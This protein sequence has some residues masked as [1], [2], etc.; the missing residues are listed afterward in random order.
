VE[1]WASDLVVEAS[2][3]GNGISLSQGYKASYTGVELDDVT[4]TG[5]PSAGLAVSGVQ[6]VVIDGGSLTGNGTYGVQ[7]SSTSLVLAGLTLDGN[8]ADG[9]YATSA[10]VAADACAFTGNASSG[11]SS[12][13]GV[14]AVTGSTVTGNTGTGIEVHGSAYTLTDDV[15]TGN[16]GF[17]LSC[18]AGSTMTSCGNDVDGNGSGDNDGC[19]ASCDRTP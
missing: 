4:V 10:E 17:G 2:A 11:V 13:Y 7:A 1:F 15:V 9:L 5:S 16:G 14:L 6:E 19:D 3:W 12:W 8:G 18:D